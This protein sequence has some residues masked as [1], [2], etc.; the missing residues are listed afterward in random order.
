MML[1]FHLFGCSFRPK[2]H[3]QSTIYT[4]EGTRYI[5]NIDLENPEEDLLCFGTSENEL[6]SETPET[7][8][9]DFLS[10]DPID[11]LESTWFFDES[12]FEERDDE[13]DEWLF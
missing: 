1:P 5:E 10:E 4:E 11:A 9:D 7:P 8:E 3:H 13:D 6:P 12:D 2:I